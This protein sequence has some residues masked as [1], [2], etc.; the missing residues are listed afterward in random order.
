MKCWEQ[1]ALPPEDSQQ[2]LLV[3]KVLRNKVTSP[4]IAR[5]DI[6]YKHIFGNISEQKEVTV[7][8][9][10]LVQAREDI[11]NETPIRPGDI[12]DPSMSNCLCYSDTL[13]TNLC[14][15][16]VAIGN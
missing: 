3:C 8:L 4:D 9:Q 16:C 12:L 6:L 2:H 7:L 15:N 11:L 10:R 1:E 14:I 5:G 13:F